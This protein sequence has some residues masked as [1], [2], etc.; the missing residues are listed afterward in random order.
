MNQF[1]DSILNPQLYKN[2][3]NPNCSRLLGLLHWVLSVL[4]LTAG[5]WFP[6]KDSNIRSQ[7]SKPETQP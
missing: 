7:G 4:L 6:A 1:Q 2:E 5:Y 3:N